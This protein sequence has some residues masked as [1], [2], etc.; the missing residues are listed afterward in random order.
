MTKWI[1]IEPKWIDIINLWKNLDKKVSDSYVFSE[2][3]RMAKVC[4]TIRQA[5]KTGK[6]LT[7][8]K[9]KVSTS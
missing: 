2:L 8:K 4:D 9:G 1:D 5:E 3:E 7:I 6:T